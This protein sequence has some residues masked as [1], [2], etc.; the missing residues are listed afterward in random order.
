MTCIVCIYESVILIHISQTVI[1]KLVQ[2]YSFFTTS[3]AIIMRIENN[4]G[5]IY[6][7]VK[8]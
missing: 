8:Y 5:L 7:T 6:T 2:S 4:I 3:E 1:Q